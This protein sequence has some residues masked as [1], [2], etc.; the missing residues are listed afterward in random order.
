MELFDRY[1]EVNAVIEG[2]N[3]QATAQHDIPYIRLHDYVHYCDVKTFLYAYTRRLRLS[4]TER[5]ELLAFCYED[6]LRLKNTLGNVDLYAFTYHYLKCMTY[7]TG[8]LDTPDDCVEKLDMERFGRYRQAREKQ[9]RDEPL[10]AEETALVQRTVS[11]AL[12]AL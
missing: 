11:D 6:T 7:R 1:E 3:R 5:K 9:W 8:N 10:T 2:M 4:E 12:D